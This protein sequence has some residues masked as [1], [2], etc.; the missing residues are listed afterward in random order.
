MLCTT[1]AKMNSCVHMS[2][3]FTAVGHSMFQTVG[4]DTANIVFCIELKSRQHYK[5][6]NYK[7]KNSVNVLIRKS[8]YTKIL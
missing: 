8:I 3:F 5:Y 6:K 2:L 4:P 1:F 7:Y